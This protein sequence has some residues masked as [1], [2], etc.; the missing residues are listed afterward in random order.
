MARTGYTRLT[1][2]LA[3]VLALPVSCAVLAQRALHAEAANPASAPPLRMAQIDD[4]GDIEVFDEPDSVDL[5]AGLRHGGSPD[6]VRPGD[7]ELPDVLVFSYVSDWEESLTELIAVINQRV[8]LLFLVTPEETHEAGF[9][10]WSQAN[11]VNYLVAEHDSPWVRDYGPM[12]V[13]ENGQATWLDLDYGEERASDNRIPERLAEAFEASIS[14]ESLV[15]DG[16]ALVSNGEGLCAM[17]ETSLSG[18]NLNLM[19]DDEWNG[20]LSTLGCEALSVV[21]ALPEE[22][23]GHVDIFMQFLAPDVVGISEAVDDPEVA[24]I[25]KLA[26]LALQAS[27]HALGTELTFVRLPM[28]RA[29][30][31]YFTYANSLRVGKQLLLPTYSNFD[32]ALEATVKERLGAALQGVSLHFIEADAMIQLGGALHCLGLGLHLTPRRS[33]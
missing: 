23:T 5:P 22:E 26:E 11:F 28:P 21:P 32:A 13:F 29:G 9:Q 4:G 1:T 18:L 33:L 10:A 2:A 7:F 31:R 8:P 24:E 25:L 19:D 12:S 30:L 20:L 16:G 6:R 15:L 14:I 27:A 17:T 3:L